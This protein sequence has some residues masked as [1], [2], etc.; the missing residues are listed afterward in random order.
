MFSNHLKLWYAK[1]GYDNICRILN[2]GG[3][4]AWFEYCPI[5]PIHIG[6][7]RWTLRETGRLNDAGDKRKITKPP[8]APPEG[9]TRNPEIV[10]T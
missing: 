7:W 5:Q 2:S 1:N 6:K 9:R 3:D 4:G 10:R 8:R